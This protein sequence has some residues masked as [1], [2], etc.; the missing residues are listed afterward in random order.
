MVSTSS[1]DAENEELDQFH[2][3]FEWHALRIKKD[4]GMKTFAK[5]CIYCRSTFKI[6]TNLIC[7]P[8][9]YCPQF[10]EFQIC[11]NPVTYFLYGPL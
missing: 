10:E 3:K 7:N 5:Q 11:G 4:R 1:L 8:Q 2:S 6:V 9:F